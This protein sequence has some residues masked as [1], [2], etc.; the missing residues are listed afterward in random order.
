MQVLSLKEFCAGGT[1]HSC[2]DSGLERAPPALQAQQGRWTHQGCWRVPELL[3]HTVG[4]DSATCGEGMRHP[5]A[6][7]GISVQP[8]TCGV[9]HA[10]S[11]QQWAFKM[12]PVGWLS[13]FNFFHMMWEPFK[14]LHSSLTSLVL[15]RSEGNV[16][17]AKKL[18]VRNISCWDHYISQTQ[19]III[20]QLL[21]MS[22]P[23]THRLCT[24]TLLTKCRNLT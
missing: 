10:H 19:F 22:L 6:R 12:H 13:V 24:I 1:W 15:V 20:S 4:M 21:K 3:C 11:C 7:V 17:G 5:G 18:C 23:H 9:C 14:R 2:S 16:Q 8:S